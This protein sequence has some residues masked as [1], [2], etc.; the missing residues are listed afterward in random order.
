MLNADETMQTKSVRNA[1]VG[2][3]LLAGIACPS[4]SHFLYAEMSSTNYRIDWDTVST[5]G[6]DTSSSASYTLR[7]T[8][9]NPAAGSASSS[10]YGLEGGYRIAIEDQ[11]L[12]FAV[13]AQVVSSGVNASSLA[14]NIVTI[15]SSSGFSVDDYALVVQDVGQNQVAALGKIS[16]LTATTLSFDDLVNGGSAPVIDG[17][18]DKVF[19]LEGS[20]LAFD[21]LN[22]SE[23]VTEVIAFE[24]TAA[25]DNG[26][27]VQI[28]EDGDLRSG[29]FAIDDVIDG[30]IVAGSE[31]YGA[32]SSDTSVAG[33]TFDTADTAITTSLQPIVTTSSASFSSRS[34]LTLKA[35]VANSTPA[36]TY[37]QVLTV[38]A[39]GNY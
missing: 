31:E 2:L 33:S 21:V 37:A 5:G 20:T 12:S 1:M 11:V 26:Y 16:S 24:V 38:V 10:S 34:F 4:F 18:N 6:L 14:S 27:S 22:T 39:T 23:V 30:A 8:I 13:L 25:I 35:A 15:D 19:L 7:D 29:S 32:R 9:G 3:T 36:G 17:G 28:S